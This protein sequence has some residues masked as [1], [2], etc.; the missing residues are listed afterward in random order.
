MK[1]LYTRKKQLHNKAFLTKQV[2]SIIRCKA[3]PKFKNPS[4]PTI[5]CT[6]GNQTTDRALLDLGASANLLPY[7]VYLQLELDELKPTSVILQLADRS[8]KVPRGIVED[9]LIQVDKFYFLV[10]FNLYSTCA[11]F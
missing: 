5:S 11:R 1:D 10:D 3:P 8:V 7:S 9:A 4:C 6:I 2:S